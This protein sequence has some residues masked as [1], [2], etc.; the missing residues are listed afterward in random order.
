MLINRL[1]YLL[2]QNISN[3][4]SLHMKSFIHH[5]MQNVVTNSLQFVNYTVSRQTGRK[6]RISEPEEEGKESLLITLGEIPLISPY[7]CFKHQV[8]PQLLF[9]KKHS[10]LS[11]VCSVCPLEKSQHTNSIFPLNVLT[12]SH[13]SKRKRNEA[14]RN[15]KD[16]ITDYVCGSS[17]FRVLWWW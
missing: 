13:V 7:T 12:S 10:A 3:N 15:V 17:V 14:P 2:F 1:Q 4:R 5:V 9:Q 16:S 6:E 8:P 11:F